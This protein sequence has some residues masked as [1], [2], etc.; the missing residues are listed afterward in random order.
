MRHFE[1][2]ICAWNYSI[3][4]QDEVGDADVRVYIIF[5]E[6]DPVMINSS[7]SFSKRDQR[8]QEKKE[9]FHIYLQEI[10]KCLRSV[11]K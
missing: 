1:D 7:P 6:R 5:E 10:I 9:Q 11:T 8:A 3:K 4:L 2:P